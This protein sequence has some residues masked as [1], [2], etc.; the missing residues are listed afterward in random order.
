MKEGDWR[1][2]A[3][4]SDMSFGAEFTHKGT[5]VVGDIGGLNASV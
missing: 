2:A 5:C 4:E 1:V 3:R